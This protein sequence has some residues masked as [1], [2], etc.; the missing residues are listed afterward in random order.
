MNISLRITDFF[1]TI[2]NIFF[3][4]FSLI[5]MLKLDEPFRDQNIFKIYLFTTVQIWV[6][7]VKEYLF[8]VFCCNF[9]PWIQIRG[10]AYFCD[11]DPDP[12]SQNLS[13]PMVQDSDPKHWFKTNISGGIL[14]LM[15]VCCIDC[16][17]PPRY[18]NSNYFSA[19]LIFTDCRLFKRIIFCVY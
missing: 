14:G 1:L 7:I 9:A 11:P 18:C 4:F 19:I 5:F 10:S 8:S 12:G 2:V 17:Y 6:L 3:I 15:L 13:D 16:I